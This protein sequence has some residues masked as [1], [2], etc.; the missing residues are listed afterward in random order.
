MPLAGG[1]DR[2]SRTLVRV[3]TTADDH[4]SRLRG[5]D[6]FSGAVE[7]LVASEGVEAVLALAESWGS[8]DDVEVRGIALGALGDMASPEAPRAAALILEQ[9]RRVSEP[10]DAW[11]RWRAAGA[12]WAV[13][14]ALP[15]MRP[16]VAD[17]LRHAALAELL[18]FAEDEDDEVRHEVAVGLPGLLGAD[19]EPMDPGV[20][21]LVRLF[22]DPEARSWAVFAF[23]DQLTVDSPR[24]RDELLA[25]ATQ[26]LGGEA[27]AEAADALAQRGDTRVIPVLLRQLAHDDVSDLWIGVAATMPDPVLLPA[28]EHLKAIGWAART[29]DPADMTYGY[30]EGAHW[31]DV[32]IAAAQE[33]RDA[34]RA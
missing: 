10:D 22:H 17:T 33:R 16:D 21:A 3:T 15:A 9:V 5:A 29:I 7:E 24:I 14:H 6:Y 11:L 26:D 20:E 4:L 1:V 27:A 19:A 31:L 8:S 30:P 13:A 18:R 12:V 28:L 2:F 23:T 32:A 34:L 25:V